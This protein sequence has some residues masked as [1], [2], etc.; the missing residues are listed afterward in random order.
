[1]RHEDLGFS[2]RSWFVANEWL[3]AGRAN[4]TAASRGGVDG[5]LVSG[6][7]RSR[8]PNRGGESNSDHGDRTFRVRSEEICES[9]VRSLENA[10]RLTPIR[11]LAGG[12]TYRILDGFRRTAAVRVLGWKT[13]DAVVNAPM[14]AAEARKIAF[15]ANVVGEA[16][17]VLERANGIQLARRE[18]HAK[19]DVAEMFGISQR[20]VERYPALPDGVLERIDGRSI[21]MAHAHVLVAHVPAI[22]LADGQGTYRSGPCRATAHRREHRARQ[23]R[24]HDTQISPYLVGCDPRTGP[25]FPTAGGPS[26]RGIQQRP[27]RPVRRRIRERIRLGSEAGRRLGGVSATSR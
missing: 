26:H 3:G 27:D 16:L 23:G 8:G 24:F 6:S 17:T 13:I 4:S 20:Q 2:P 21:T 15:V 5:C 25:R 7:S 9:L 10:G 11:V 14:F 19:P 12:E 22:P 1:M 18:G